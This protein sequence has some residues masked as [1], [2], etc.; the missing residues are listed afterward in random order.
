MDYGEVVKVGHSS[1]MLGR[2]AGGTGRG[3]PRRCFGL[4]LI[5]LG[6]DEPRGCGPAWPSAV[7]AAIGV[8]S[9]GPGSRPARALEALSSIG[10]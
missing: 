9:Y 4:S 3:E 6:D 5:G 1:R 7:A 8:D 10:S 2:P